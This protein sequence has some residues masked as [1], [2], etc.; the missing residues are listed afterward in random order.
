MRKTGKIALISLLE[1]CMMAV[2]VIMLILRGPE[3]LKSVYV[4]NISLDVAGMAIAYILLVCCVIDV[5]KIG[6]GSRRFIYLLCLV[7]VGM[8]SDALAWLV[9]GIPALRFVNI[10]DNTV[11]Y[12]CMPLGACLFWYYVTSYLK[13]DP[14]TEARFGR[15]M[16]AGL[17]ITLSFCI[18]NLF[19]GIYFTVGADGVYSRSRLYPIHQAYGYIMIFLTLWIIIKQHRSLQRYQIA[20]MIMYVAA[21][22]FVSCLTIMV[23]GLSIAYPVMVAVLLL[24][25]CVITVTQG[26]EQEAAEKD[27]NLASA[28]QENVLPRVFPP[29]PD[30]KDIDIYA[31]MKPAKEVGGDFYDFFL[32]DDDHLAMVIA[33]VSGKGVP[34]ALLMMVCKGL[35]KNSL[36][37]GAGPGRTLANVNRQLVE[38]DSG[39]DMFVTVWLAVLEISTGK[40]IAANA[41]HEHPALKRADGRFELIMYSHAPAV[42]AMDGIPYTEHGFEM[43]AGDVL[44]VYT[45][46]VAEAM[47]NDD[48]LFDTDRMIEALNRETQAPPR[49]LIENVKNAVDD[50]TAG[51]RQF[52][53]MTMLCLKYYGSSGE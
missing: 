1:L 5:K 52:D 17:I 28:I 34:A 46:G 48:E 47:N 45:D 29:Y 49:Q 18:L 6:K 14:K 53:D 26:R 20:A 50:F 39:I 51:A 11:Y 23:Y 41:G 13:P 10:L 8:L 38:S 42:G 32:I 21:P 33:D 4:I 12:M 3:D 19:T 9:D 22:L 15:I 35:I 2:P 31:L 24:M 36:L 16:Q 40:G 44:F 7:T 43:H 37:A 30:R 27:L 25:Y